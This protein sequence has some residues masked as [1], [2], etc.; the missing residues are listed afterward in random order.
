MIAD[1]LSRTLLQPGE[2]TLH[3]EV[4]FSLVE[5]WRHPQIDLF[6][7]YLNF[8]LVVPGRGTSDSICTGPGVGLRASVIPSVWNSGTCCQ[9]ESSEQ[10]E[11]HHNSPSL[12]E[13]GMVLPSLGPQ[14]GA[15]ST[16][17]RETR[18]SPAARNPPSATRNAQ[19]GGGD[20]E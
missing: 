12:A 6:A 2:W 1:Y 18:S 3:P 4:F 7:K 19:T 8:L 11:V 17:T 16:T 10:G 15:C 5:R 20:P 14:L 9:E 13:A